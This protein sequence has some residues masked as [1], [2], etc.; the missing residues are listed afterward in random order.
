MSILMGQ[1]QSEVASHLIKSISY[2]ALNQLFSDFYVGAFRN[3]LNTGSKIDYFDI[4]IGDAFVK[5]WRQMQTGNVRSE[6]N[7][8]HS[9]VNAIERLLGRRAA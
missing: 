3:V 1:F 5:R 7:A 8:C 9:V 4:R 2:Q 6:N